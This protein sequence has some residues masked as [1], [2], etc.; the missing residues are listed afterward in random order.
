[1]NAGLH[2]AVVGVLVV[3]PP[4]ASAQSPDDRGWFL[5]ASVLEVDSSA[6]QER[7]V[8]HPNFFQQYV[9]QSAFSGADRRG[10]AVKGSRA[11]TR[12]FALQAGYYELGELSAPWQCVGIGCPT[13][14]VPVPP[15]AA[16]LE[17]FSLAAVGTWPL[18]ER[19]D[20]FGK[21]GTFRVD[22][23]VAPS[24]PLAPQDDRGR[25]VLRGAGVGVWLT[26]RW[27]L[28]MQY[29]RADIAFE[30]LGIGATYR[31]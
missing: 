20:L 24:F 29:E 13:P 2:L 25:E 10:F 12:H 17:A 30:S 26:P 9:L 11:F 28:D 19:V 4:V 3:A 22:L 6:Y 21:L 16:E 7:R 18:S 14:L 15:T 23:D 1:M 8:S 5:E 31:F 27:R